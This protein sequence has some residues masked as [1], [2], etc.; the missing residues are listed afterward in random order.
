MQFDKLIEKRLA[1][2]YFD[3]PSKAKTPIQVLHRKRKGNKNLTI[4]FMPWQSGPVMQRWIVKQVPKNTDA[5]AITP[6]S[7]LLSDAQETIA[8][9]KQVCNEA[10]DCVADYLTQ[11]KYQHINVIGLSV[12]TGV[13]AYVTNR[14]YE[15]VSIEFVDL[16]CPGAELSTSL[17]LGSRTANL[18]KTYEEAGYSLEKVRKMWSEVDLINN[19]NFADTVPVRISYSLSDTVIVPEQS[20]EVIKNVARRRANEPRVKRNRF[21]GHYLTMFWVWLVWR[22]RYQPRVRAHRL[23]ADRAVGS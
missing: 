2:T 20:E 23:E 7:L 12:G 11:H 16:V 17:W 15:K 5:I 18:K 21:L 10:L 14:L 4:L 3:A 22:L 19:L 13:A 1:K 8:L 6:R 9:C